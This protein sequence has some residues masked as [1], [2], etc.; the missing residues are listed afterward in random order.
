MNHTTIKRALSLTLYLTAALFTYG[1]AM[2]FEFEFMLGISFTGVT[3]TIMIAFNE[4]VKTKV[5]QI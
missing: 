2:E 4:V 3:A 1:L 5:N